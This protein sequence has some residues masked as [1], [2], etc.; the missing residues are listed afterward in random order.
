[1]REKIP[2]ELVDALSKKKGFSLLIKGA[3]GTGKTI[4]A[5]EIIRMFGCANAVYLSSRV[6]ATSLYEQFPW[7]DACIEPLNLMDVTKLYSSSEGVPRVEPFPDVLYSRLDQIGKPA[8]V[9]ID[10]WDAIASQMGGEK[11]EMFEASITQLVSGNEMKLILVSETLGTT[12]RDFI[13]DGVVTLKRPLIDYRRVRELKLEKLRGVRIHQPRYAFTLEN[14]EF[15]YIKPFKR[16]SIKKP[17]II[18]SFPGSERYVSTGSEDLDRVLGGGLRR[19]SFNVIEFGDDLS[20]WGYQMLTVFMI[21]N[22]IE[23]R[24]H[25]V[26]LP[27]CAWDEKGLRRELLPFVNEEDYKKYVT[28]FEVAPGKKGTEKRKN[29]KFL[30]GESIASDFGEIESFISELEPPVLITIGTDVLE[31]PYHL[32]ERGRL[33]TMVR[34][35]SRLMAD[36]REAGNVAVL[37]TNP[38]LLL[39][40]ELTHL[41]NTYLKLTTLDNSVVLYGIRPETGLYCQ[42]STIVDDHLKLELTPYL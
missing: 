10:S 6:P 23:Q 41:S 12:S 35:L 8:I 1:M 13:V 27:G 17:L 2:P 11:N 9:V 30:E 19:G 38:K 34:W 32:K 36:T 24:S 3:P 7:L 5:L 22:S 14:G 37:G 18:N 21:I 26:S 42:D 40:G 20:I 39:H 28:F 33:G 4:L 15:Q 29:V 31:H 25:C 16:K